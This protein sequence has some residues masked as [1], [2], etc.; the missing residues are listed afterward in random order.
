MSDLESYGF[1]GDD[2]MSIDLNADGTAKFNIG[3]LVTSMMGDSADLGAMQ[4]MMDAADIK[5]TATGS[6][7]DL[8]VAGSTLSMKAESDGGLSLEQSGT[9]I[10]FAKQ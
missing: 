3:S 2:L 6:G 10:V 5:W 7:V 8:S 4:Q 9:K 1:T